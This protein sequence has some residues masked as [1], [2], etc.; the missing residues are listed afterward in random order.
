MTARKQRMTSASK[1][2]TPDGTS[3]PPSSSPSLGE[4]VGA[5][6]APRGGRSSSASADDRISW[7]LVLP[8][9]VAIVVVGAALGML[10][11]SVVDAIRIVSFVLIGAAVIMIAVALVLYLRNRRRAAVPATATSAEAAPATRAADPSYV[12]SNARPAEARVDV[13]AQVPAASNGTAA[14]GSAANGVAAGAAG[15]ANGAGQPNTNAG[16]R[17][18]QLA[19][20]AAASV[21]RPPVPQVARAEVL[22]AIAPYAEVIGR[23]VYYNETVEARNVAGDDH[24]ASDLAAAGPAASP[25]PPPPPPKATVPPPPPPVPSPTVNQPVD[26]SARTAPAPTQTTPAAV[27]APVPVASVPAPAVAAVVAAAPASAHVAAPTGPPPPPAPAPAAAPVPAMAEAMVPS[28]DVPGWSR[29]SAIPAARANP[30]PERASAEM[31]ARSAVGSVAPV[32]VYRYRKWVLGQMVPGAPFEAV[33]VDRSPDEWLLLSTCGVATLMAWTHEDHHFTYPVET[34]AD[35][36]LPAHGVRIRDRELAVDLLLAAALHAG[37]IDSVP[38]DRLRRYQASDLVTAMASIHVG[39]L[40]LYCG[41]GRIGP[42]RVLAD[43]YGIGPGD[44]P[45]H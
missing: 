15:V 30:A 36:I 38:T 44:I 32:I 17:A 35:E 22:D 42:E 37:G 2:M 7:R 9:F 20:A 24:L 28:D 5:G 43:Q 41:L 25:P 14:Y 12:T 33:T 27:Q 45:L 39:L 6:S 31:A 8:A 10:A 11:R 3:A 21:A 13:I 19:P 29:S 1:A 40:R 16:T 23:P 34:W 26:V 18:G 4:L